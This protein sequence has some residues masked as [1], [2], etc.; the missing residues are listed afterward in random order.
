MRVPKQSPKE[1]RPATVAKALTA[2]ADEQPCVDRPDAENI[3]FGCAGGE[4]D[5]DT[6]LGA[7]FPNP[8]AREKFCRCVSNKSGVPRSDIPC[9]SSTTIEDVIEAIT[10]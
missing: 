1:V 3:V 5:V 7:L 4:I 8:T 9:G 10:C 6:E 2:A